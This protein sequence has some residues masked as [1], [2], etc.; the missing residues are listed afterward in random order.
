MR[1]IA[2]LA[3]E[4]GISTGTVSRALNGKRDV[5][6]ETKRK[7]ME[8]AARLGYAPNQA[9]RALAQGTTRS[10]G[11]MIEL[12]PETA[13]SSDYFFMGVFDGVQSVLTRHGLDLLVLPCPTTQDR[14]HYLERFVARGVVDGI[15]LASTQRVD[16]RVDLLQSVGVPFVTLGRSTSGQGYSWIDLDFEGVVNTSI[17]RLVAL[18]HRRIA[19]TLP[20][21]EVNFGAVFEA[22]YRS[23][24]LRHGLEFDPRLMFVTRRSEQAG[25]RIVDEMIA[26]EAAPTAVL[27]I[28]EVAAI[29]IYRRLAELG[30]TPGRDLSIVGLRDEP[31]VRFLEPSVTCFSVSLRDI[32]VAI[33]E[34][35][36]AQL[37]AHA[38]AYPPGIVQKLAHL[39]LRA[40][41][42]D[43]PARS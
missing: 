34:A 11:F 38:G 12:D 3:K 21:G 25:Y 29:G 35:M 15:I 41:E 7:V 40:G 37:P 20:F 24:L 14:Y 22:A 33:A 8:A 9:A 23:A 27:L 32:G 42:S 28:Y 31:T 2:Q 36:L 17:D 18:G 39:E 16:Q 6:D 43:G 30:L 19:L 26:L 4:L 1:G 10:I 13:A 5:S